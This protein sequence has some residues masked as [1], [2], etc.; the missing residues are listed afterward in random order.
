MFTLKLTEKMHLN[1]NYYHGLFVYLPFLLNGEHERGAVF[2]LNEFDLFTYDIQKWNAL[3]L[4]Y[5]DVNI[6]LSTIMWACV[7]FCSNMSL[8]I[9]WYHICAAAYPVCQQDSNKCKYFKTTLGLTISIFFRFLAL[10]L[11]TEVGANNIDINL[12]ITRFN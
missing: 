1:D 12:E 6:S 5:K 4:K 10:A 8:R 2:I 11:L 7:D 3:L 9:F